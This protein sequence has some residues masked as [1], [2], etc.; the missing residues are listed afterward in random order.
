MNKVH[1]HRMGKRRAN[2]ALPRQGAR[3]QPSERSFGWHS[4]IRLELAGATKRW[5]AALPRLISI[6]SFASTLVLAILESFNELS[7]GAVEAEVG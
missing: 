6:P 1:K 2:T 7:F 5:I 3:I 4:N